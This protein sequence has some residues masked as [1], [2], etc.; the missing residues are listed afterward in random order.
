MYNMYL[1]TTPERLV[2]SRL[3]IADYGS[4][5]RLARA[6]CINSDIVYMQ[7]WKD[8]V[9]GAGGRV[10]QSAI[11]GSSSPP[12]FLFLGVNFDFEILCC[13][14]AGAYTR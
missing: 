8:C 1:Q 10:T 2:L 4:A 9:V 11:I 7:Q 13:R 12:W 3:E 6:F 5:L 14:I